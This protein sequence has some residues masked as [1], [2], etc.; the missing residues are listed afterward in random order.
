MRIE[1]PL[2]EDVLVVHHV[3]E[4]ELRVQPRRRQELKKVPWVPSV[5]SVSPEPLSM[6][7]RIHGFAHTSIRR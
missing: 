7:S 2:H 3:V 1:H 5:G 6:P 4:G